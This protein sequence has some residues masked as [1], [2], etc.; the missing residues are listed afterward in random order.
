VPRDFDG[1]RIADAAIYRPSTGQWFVL[2]SST[3]AMM[4]VQWSVSSDQ[5]LFRGESR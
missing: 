2:K 5:P 4:A 1:D 3:G